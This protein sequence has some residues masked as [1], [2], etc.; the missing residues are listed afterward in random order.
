MR[1]EPPSDFPTDV[2]S[3]TLS[4]A[5]ERTAG[6]R[7][8][9]KTPR[10]GEGQSLAD[11]PAV[12]VRSDRYLYVPRVFDARSCQE[13]HPGVLFGSEHGGIL[14]GWFGHTGWLDG[15][16]D[17]G[18]LHGTPKCGHEGKKL[19]E[20]LT[21]MSCAGNLDSF[22][23]A[24]LMTRPLLITSKWVYGMASYELWALETNI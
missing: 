7:A 5:F 23:Y 6:G 13:I 11:Q 12:P 8:G 20:L 14:D 24:A 21:N 22:P 16:E 10:V 18:S 2:R 3:R 1:K 15:R 4:P 19:G 17:L 9:R